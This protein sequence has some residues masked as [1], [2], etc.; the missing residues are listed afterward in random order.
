MPLATVSHQNI[1]LEIMFK[2]RE[3]DFFFWGGGGN[4]GKRTVIIVG[5]LDLILCIMYYRLM[6]HGE[7]GL[8]VKTLALDL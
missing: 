3:K 2:D 1:A 5:K 7:V 4:I 6:G 8:H